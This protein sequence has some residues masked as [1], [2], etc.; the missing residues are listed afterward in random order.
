MPVITVAASEVAP[1]VARLE[2][3]GHTVTAIMP[4]APHGAVFVL[5]QTKPKTPRKRPD[6]QVETR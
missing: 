2:K 6:Q 4:G 3:A 5:F 1:E